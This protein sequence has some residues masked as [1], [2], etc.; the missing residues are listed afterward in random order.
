M[1]LEWRGT[2]PAG[3]ALENIEIRLAHTRTRILELTLSS[4]NGRDSF[5]LD[6]SVAR[7]RL[8]EPLAPP[9]ESV[10]L[11][12][13]IRF[14]GEP[15]RP[16]GILINDGKTVDLPDWLPAESALPRKM[17]EAVARRLWALERQ[18]VSVP[19]V[20]LN[21]APGSPVAPGAA[22]LETDVFAERALAIERGALLRKAFLAHD[23]ATNPRLQPEKWALHMAHLN[24][25]LGDRIRAY[26]W[27]G[28]E[29]KW[30]DFPAV[31]GPLLEQLRFV[32]DEFRTSF[33]DVETHLGPTGP[34]DLYDWAFEHFV[35]GA[36]ATQHNDMDWQEVLGSHGT[37][38][39]TFVLRYA[40]LAIVAV[41]SDVDAEFWRARV[42][43]LVRASH[44]YL[45][46][47]APLAEAPYPSP[48]WHFRFNPGIAYPN[49]RRR[50]L[51]A[52]YADLAAPD[53]EE[54]F[55]RLRARFASLLGRAL[56]QPG[57]FGSTVTKVA[58]PDE[59][60]ATLR[61]QGVGEPYP[62][63]SDSTPVLSLT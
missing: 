30:P 55:N 29:S 52:A 6:G 61:A 5:Q 11:T 17:P 44:I 57:V 62:L 21:A 31:E 43:T 35:T 14:E 15:P 46:L 39:S 8:R 47:A 41:E 53:P 1:Q 40:A 34:V 63:A 38:D 2:L 27:A 59:L 45:E 49:E 26:V 19:V 33:A 23:Q 51:R 32:C 12:L 22:P 25:V 16:I 50:E 48:E 18:R 37:P 4:P 58:V 3:V 54:H 24:S 10:G 60:L 28:S 13:G 9:S 20:L 56:Q 7:V 42:S 36:L